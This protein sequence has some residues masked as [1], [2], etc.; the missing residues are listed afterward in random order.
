MT[1]QELLSRVNELPKVSSVVQELVSML[2]DPD[3]DFAMLAKKDI[4][5]PS[6]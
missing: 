6:D 3:C 5:G 2:N 1:E 4:H